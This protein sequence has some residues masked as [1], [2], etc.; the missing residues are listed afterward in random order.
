MTRHTPKARTSTAIALLISL[1]WLLAPLAIR[2]HVVLAAIA[3]TV[4]AGALASF[5]TSIFL[6]LRRT[7]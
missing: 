3:V 1:T 6:A 4:I 5:A 7:P 2:S